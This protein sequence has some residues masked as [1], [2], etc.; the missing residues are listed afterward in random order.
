MK[1]SRKLACDVFG[2][3]ATN[4]G[5]V[6]DVTDPECW[7]ENDSTQLCFCNLEMLILSKQDQKLSEGSK[8]RE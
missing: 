1:S 3:F 2:T 8:K 5:L 4:S 6:D 7:T